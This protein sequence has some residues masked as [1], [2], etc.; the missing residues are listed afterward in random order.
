MRIFGLFWVLIV[1]AGCATTPSAPPEP[2]IAVQLRGTA[3]EVQ[4]F[5]EERLRQN[6]QSGLHVDGANDRELRFKGDC[7]DTPGMGAFKCSLVMMAVGN[8]GWD[9]PFAVVTFRTAEIRGVVNL[10]VQTKWCATNALGKTNCMDNGTNKD[11]NDMLRSI[12][13]A[14][15]TEV[16]PLER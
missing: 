5:I 3:V 15:T 11:R 4:N 6:P 8:S 16:R 10:T 12:E 2:E 13:S 1:L 14:Y 7:I 9:G